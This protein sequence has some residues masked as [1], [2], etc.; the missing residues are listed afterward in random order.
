MYPSIGEKRK[1]L[2]ALTREQAEE[3]LSEAT[4]ETT[5]AVCLGCINRSE[6]RHTVGYVHVDQPCVRCA[7]PTGQRYLYDVL[8]PHYEAVMGLGQYTSSYSTCTALVR[9]F[10][11][12]LDVNCWYRDLGLR[13]GAS[14]REIRQRLKSVS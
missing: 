7:A 10:R 12:V 1:A 4:T 11:L 6:G 2:A 14:L 9:P 13:P 5:V 8:E 3:R